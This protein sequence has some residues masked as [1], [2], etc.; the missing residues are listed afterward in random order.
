MSKLSRPCRDFTS[1]PYRYLPPYIAKAL[2]ALASGNTQNCA[3]I[4]KSLLAAAGAPGPGGTAGDSGVAPGEDSNALFGEDAPGPSPQVS[5]MLTASERAICKE[6][7]CNP[8]MYAA[9]KKA[10]TGGV[11]PPRL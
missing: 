3:K 5:S 11:T 9:V 4:L 10:S 8:K 6:V 7:G 2:D 1:I